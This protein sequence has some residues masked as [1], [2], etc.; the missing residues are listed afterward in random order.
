MPDADERDGPPGDH[1]EIPSEPADF[2]AAIVQ[3]LINTK[4]PE[5]AVERVSVVDFAL[6][7]EG[8][9]RV[10]PH[11]ESRSTSITQKT[12]PTSCHGG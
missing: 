11:G 10:P 12:H 1:R 9:Q 4:Y 8:E 5:V 3:G 6:S 7:T 2:D